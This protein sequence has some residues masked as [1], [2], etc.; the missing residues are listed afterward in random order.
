MKVSITNPGSLFEMFL[1][2]VD[3][4][5]RLV[6]RLIGIPTACSSKSHNSASDS[7]LF[8]DLTLRQI[9][10]VVGINYL[11]SSIQR[12]WLHVDHETVSRVAK[13]IG[14]LALIEQHLDQMPRTRA[15]LDS[16]I[17]S[18]EDFQIR[19]V[20]WAV[21]ALDL[22]GEEV[23]RWKVVRMAGLKPDYSEKGDR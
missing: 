15:Y 13:A 23:L 12:V 8:S 14:Q 10:I 1:R 4:R 6:G 5:E 3:R 20:R 7:K 16:V 21:E 18:L 22:R 11:L 17:E 19:R 2:E 9:S